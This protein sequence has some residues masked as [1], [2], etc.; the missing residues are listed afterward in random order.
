MNKHKEE[1]LHTK[2][3]SESCPPQT[4]GHG[5]KPA[6]CPASIPEPDQ[7]RLNLLGSGK[8]LQAVMDNIREHINLIAPDGTILWHNSGLNEPHSIPQGSKCWKLFERRNERCS[9]CVHPAILSDGKPRDY[10]AQTPTDGGAPLEWWVRAVPMRDDRG[11]IYAILE[12]A[13][14]ITEKKRLER[15]RREMESNMQQVQKLESLGILAGGM[16]HDFNNMITAINGHSEMLLNKVPP[17]DPIYQSILDIWK[18]GQC[19]ADMTRQLL[20]FARRQPVSPKVLDINDNMEKMLQLLRRPLGKNIEIVWNPDKNVCP[21]R[22]DPSQIDQIITNLLLNARDAIAGTGQVTIETFNSDLDQAYCDSHAGSIPGK[23]ATLAVKDNG[24]GMD[25]ETMKHIFEPFFTT[26]ETGKGTGLGLATV[27]GIV[28]QNNGFIDICSEPG[29]G[30]TFKIHLPVHE[31]KDEMTGHASEMRSIPA[32]NETVL[33][34][35]DNESLLHLFKR[36]IGNLGYN[37]LPAVN[38]IRA[39]ELADEYNG[40]IHLLMTDMIMPKMNGHELRDRIRTIRPDIRC[41]FM[42]GYA[43]DVIPHDGYSGGDVHF[44]QK[45]FSEKEMSKKI[46]EVLPPK[47]V[48]PAP[49]ESSQTT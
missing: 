11:E 35:E 24:C 3:K 44:I 29:K 16:A 25:K 41:L 9:H 28:K 34:V 43:A 39:I 27:F 15:E 42:S 4:N 8:Y 48:P 5:K 37:V 36:Q 21:V 19:S 10:E 17:S 18:A 33:M 6:D 32:G 49:P 38:P 40:E 20:A 22:I 26:K 23:Y 46:R 30:S 13:I 31:P 2:P 47:A 12:T 14:D 45:P 1:Y 7:A